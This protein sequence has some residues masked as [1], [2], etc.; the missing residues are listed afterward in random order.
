MGES[1]K[2]EQ[3]VVERATHH[4]AD[5]VRSTRSHANTERL[6]QRE[7]F[8]RFLIELLQNA[9]D[10]W[11]QHPAHEERSSAVRI[12][13]TADHVL[14]VWNEGVPITPAVILNSIGAVGEG[15]KEFGLSIGHKGIGFKA[16]LEV[17]LSPEKLFAKFVLIG[18]QIA[19]SRVPGGDRV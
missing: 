18:G 15:T 8:G 10:A 4:T 11:L 13:L 1:G 9:R 14:E 12:K 19:A 2:I 6:F 7:Y 16:V 3:V 5:E 17:T